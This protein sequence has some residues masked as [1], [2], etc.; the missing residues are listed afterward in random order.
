MT[1]RVPP[2][3]AFAAVGLFPA[4]LLG[5]GA[6]GGGWPL[7]AGFLWMAFAAPAADTIIARGFGD[8]PE[9]AQFPMADMASFQLALG[10]FALLI[11]ALYGFSGDWLSGWERVA[12]FLG[13]GMYFG[14]VS[15]SN[16]HELIHR[17][18]KAL[19]RLGAA[20]YV[21]LLFGHHVSAHRLVHHI[22]VATDADPN[23]A[24]LG[25]S[26]WRF[27]PRAWFGSF[28]AGLAVER[29]RAG[30]SGRRNPYTVWVGGGLACIVAVALIFGA[31]AA[32]DY[33]LL[34]LYAQ[35][36]LMLSDYVQHYGLRRQLHNG[37]PEPVGPRHSW[38]APHPLSSLAMVNAPRHSD[39]HAHP[40]REYPALRLEPQNKRPMLPYSLPVMGAMAMLP[41]LWR[42][43]MDRRVARMMGE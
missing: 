37:R 39:H 40:S 19:F 35:M 12:L 42:R 38:D 8:A 28:R 41:P 4:F 26:F 43:M 36:Q 30:Q 1:Y 22:H 34:C 2:A 33:L 6:M 5:W 20:V 32:V 24:R 21:S 3:A 25:E 7:W 18:R 9:G 16:A 15:N 17:G 14:Q 10:H 31:R 13:T 27:F 29:K 23:S 11:A